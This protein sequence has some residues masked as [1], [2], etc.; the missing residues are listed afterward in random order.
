[1]DKYLKFNGTASRSEY[2][3]VMLI[4]I[5]VMFVTAILAL[6]FMATGSVGAIFGAIALFA[7]FVLVGIAGFATTARRCRDADINPWFTLTLFI[8]YVGWIATI[9]FG[10]LDTKVKA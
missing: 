4:S 2:W 5:V 8:P 7:V 10:V 1:M 6:G 3:A 9:V